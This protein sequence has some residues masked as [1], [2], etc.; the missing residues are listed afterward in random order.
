MHISH[1]RCLCDL[2]ALNEQDSI[3]H[4]NCLLSIVISLHF[5]DIQYL[6]GLICMHG[7]RV[8]EQLNFTLNHQNYLK[9]IN[10][11][12]TQY[13]LYITRITRIV[14][15]N[16]QMN[17]KLLHSSSRLLVM[18]TFLYMLAFANE[19]FDDSICSLCYHY[20]TTSYPLLKRYAN[21]AEMGL[22]AS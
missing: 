5:W 8:R 11:R 13:S 21:T 7:D 14:G 18:S 16:L 10:L 4:G 19:R 15:L 2:K 20:K 3:M 12:I 1:A 6:A 9:F 17:N 22:A